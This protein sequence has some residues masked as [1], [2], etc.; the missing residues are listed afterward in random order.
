MLLQWPRVLTERSKSG[1]G[2]H[3]GQIR[4]AAERK[5]APPPP[6]RHCDP[7]Q[8]TAARVIANM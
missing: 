5:R 2:V 8:S 7:C 1:G 4:L 3:I 6:S